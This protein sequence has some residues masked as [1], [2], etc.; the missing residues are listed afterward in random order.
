MDINVR[1]IKV[2]V[3]NADETQSGPQICITLDNVPLE[4][5]TRFTYLGI[6]ISEDE[7]YDEDIKARVGMARAAFWK[8]KEILRRNI[9]LSTKMKILNS[10][11]FSTASCGCESWTWN[12]KLCKKVDAL[13]K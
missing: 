12:K 8:N 9:R 6:W 4:H 11:I 13:E 2:K 10:Q 5:V 3:V 1:K 7:R